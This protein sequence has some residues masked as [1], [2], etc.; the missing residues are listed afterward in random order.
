MWVLSRGLW[1]TDSSTTV[2]VA[3][4]LAG[5]GGGNSEGSELSSFNTEAMQKVSVCVYSPSVVV[6][7]WSTCGM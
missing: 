3:S 2:S 4:T 6:M 5:A 7:F 1:Y